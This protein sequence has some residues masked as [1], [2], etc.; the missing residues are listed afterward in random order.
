MQIKRLISKE[1]KLSAKNSRVIE[2]NNHPDC[3]F[4]INLEFCVFKN[5]PIGFL[6]VFLR[7]SLWKHQTNF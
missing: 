1:I 7:I 5:L 4:G 6:F 3:T 2:S